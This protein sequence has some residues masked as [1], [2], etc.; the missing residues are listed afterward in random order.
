[1]TQPS[2]PLPKNNTAHTLKQPWLVPQ[3]FQANGESKG[4]NK[5]VAA[6]ATADVVVG[7]RACVRV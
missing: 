6:A 4:N 3:P 5:G 2:H 7:V 1:M